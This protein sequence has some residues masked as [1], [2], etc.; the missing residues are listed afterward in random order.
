MLF[1]KVTRAPEHT[2]DERVTGREDDAI[3][4]IRCPH[5][6]WRPSAADRWCCACEFTPEPPFP[7]CGTSWNT[8]ETRG[9][10]P[11]CSHQWQWTS[12]LRC[13]EWSPHEAWYE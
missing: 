12:C 4:G 6:R 5:C 10:C 8:F 9:R 11:G 7:S 3:E 1:L 2:L 13:H